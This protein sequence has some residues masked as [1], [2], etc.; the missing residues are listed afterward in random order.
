MPHS[1]YM[2]YGNM[3]RYL[4]GYKMNRQVRGPS[5]FQFQPLTFGQSLN[6]TIAVTGSLSETHQ[7]IVSTL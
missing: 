2:S 3:M 4:L 1:V 7:G 5:E 6:V